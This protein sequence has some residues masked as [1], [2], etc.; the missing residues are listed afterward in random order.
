[1]SNIIII[2]LFGR[3][4]NIFLRLQ[5]A[6]FFMV[7][8]SRW[9]RGPHI[10]LKP[11]QCLA[12]LWSAQCQ[13]RSI[14]ISQ[15]SDIKTDIYGPHNTL[16][17]RKLTLSVFICVLTFWLTVIMSPSNISADCTIHSSTAPYHSDWLLSCHLAT[18]LLI[19]PYTTALHHSILTD[20]YHD[21]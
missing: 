11:D 5:V 16:S 13:Q 12:V 10:T 20:C 1:M 8:P 14:T 17:Q 4:G 2:A 6:W 18:F 9:L 15:N 3:F 21:T 7:A 19:S